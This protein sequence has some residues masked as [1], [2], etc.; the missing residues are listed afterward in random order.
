MS[1]SP[2]PPSGLIEIDADRQ[3]FKIDSTILTAAGVSTYKGTIIGTKSGS[4]S[5]P[6][7][8]AG[9][10]DPIITEL[11]ATTS[12]ETNIGICV[13]GASSASATSTL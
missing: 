4:S 9:S 2:T 12:S 11:P 10:T 3:S 8:N 5:N 6:N 1:V 7:Y 13:T